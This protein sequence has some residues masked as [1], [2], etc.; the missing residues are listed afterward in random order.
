MCMFKVLHSILKIN[1]NLKFKSDNKRARFTYLGYLNKVA[2]LVKRPF[3]LFMIL[4][5]CFYLI[6]TTILYQLVNFVGLTA[7][8]QFLA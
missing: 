8:I 4:F 6:R 5:F 7:E 2:K 3:G 1:L